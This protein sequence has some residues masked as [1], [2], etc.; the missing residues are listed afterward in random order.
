MARPH[1]LELAFLCRRASSFRDKL[2]YSPVVRLNKCPK[3]LMLMMGNHADFLNLPSHYAPIGLFAR[4]ALRV[5]KLIPE[6]LARRKVRVG[7]CLPFRLS[8][9]LDNQL[10]ESSR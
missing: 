6:Q 4:Y 7:L 2:I 8:N 10:V 3:S 9:A 5:A 1:Q